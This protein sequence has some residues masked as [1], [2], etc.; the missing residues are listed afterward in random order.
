MRPENQNCALNTEASAC[1]AS[2]CKGDDFCM[3]LPPSPISIRSAS[4][5]YAYLN[6]YMM[7]NR[8]PMSSPSPHIHGLIQ[9]QGSPY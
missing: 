5:L 4:G 2:V 6:R 3:I 9:T 7:R 1:V 8:A